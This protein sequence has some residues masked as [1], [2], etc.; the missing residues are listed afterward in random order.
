MP[1]AVFHAPPAGPVKVNESAGATGVTELEAAEAALAPKAL[2]ATT[3]Q[4]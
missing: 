3:E 4:V 1:E 2:L